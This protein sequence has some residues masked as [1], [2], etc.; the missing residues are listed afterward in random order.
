[1]AMIKTKLTIYFSLREL[2]CIDAAVAD[3]RM[4]RTTWLQDQSLRAAKYARRKP[5][6]LHARTPERPPAKFTHFAK[7]IFTEE[8]FEALREHAHACELP[9]SAFMRAVILGSKPRERRPLVRSAIVAVNRIGKQLNQVVQLANRGTPLAPELMNAVTG[10]LD[11]IH[12]LREELLTADAAA[13]R[14]F[15]E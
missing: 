11:T 1:M 4:R 7:T 12:T 2:A 8:Q 5:A 10:L 6:A 3:A 15:A 9:V 14:D 13:S